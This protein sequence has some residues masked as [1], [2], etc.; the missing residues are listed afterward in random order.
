MSFHLN[1]QSTLVYGKFYPMILLVRCMSKM[2]M[3]M[4]LFQLYYYFWVVYKNRLQG[5]YLC[6]YWWVWRSS[7]H[8]L[9]SD[10]CIPRIQYHCTRASIHCFLGQLLSVWTTVKA[11]LNGLIICWVGCSID[12]PTNLAKF[13]RQ[14]LFKHTWRSGFLMIW[15]SSPWRPFQCLLV[16]FLVKSY[17]ISPVVV[18]SSFLTLTPFLLG[19]TFYELT[20]L[21]TRV[22]HKMLHKRKTNTKRF[23]VSTTCT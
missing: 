1:N 8:C 18:F 22:T 14:R 23:F 10:I 17:V 2:M 9:S 13:G 11:F 15:Q 3:M 4:M 21:D 20:F 5:W 19:T 6:H 16:L 7:F 12:T